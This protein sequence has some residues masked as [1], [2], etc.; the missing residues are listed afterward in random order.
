MLDRETK[1]FGL[2]KDLQEGVLF[3]CVICDGGLT[4]A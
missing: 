1:A 3:M 2:A 4:G